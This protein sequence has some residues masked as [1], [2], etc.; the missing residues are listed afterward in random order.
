MHWFSVQIQVIIIFL[1]LIIFVFQISGSAEGKMRDMQEF[2][3][4]I[5]A[6]VERTMNLAANATIEVPFQTLM[7]NLNVTELLEALMK[8]SQDL[9]KDYASVVP[10][11][12]V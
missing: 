5:S 1:Y 6:L 8:V 2:S 9:E 7:D 11:A 10:G 12:N 4:M 3:D